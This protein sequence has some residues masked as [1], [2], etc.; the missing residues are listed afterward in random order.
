MDIDDF[1]DEFDN[2]QLDA[3]S[4]KALQDTEDRYTLYSQT[5]GNP[6]VKKDYHNKPSSRINS[7]PSTKPA[8]VIVN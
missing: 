2:F 7:V 1:E 8:R 4:L 6:A 5:S 3:E